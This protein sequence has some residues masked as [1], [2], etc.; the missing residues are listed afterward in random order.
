MVL[1][2][3]IRTLAKLA[4]LHKEMAAAGYRLEREHD[5]LPRQYYLVFSK[6]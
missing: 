4:F 6:E 5:F 2:R 1:T 3:N